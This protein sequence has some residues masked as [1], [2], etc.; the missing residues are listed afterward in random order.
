M[1]ALWNLLEALL[2]S[3]AVVGAAALHLL[4]GIW[5]IFGAFIAIALIRW[6]CIVAW[7]A[8]RAAY[9]RNRRG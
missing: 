8:G 5:I 2:A 9:K 1:D 7:N 4:L 3:L 6:G